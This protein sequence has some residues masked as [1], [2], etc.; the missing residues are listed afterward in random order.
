MQARICSDELARDVS[1]A[2]ALI[3]R[4]KENR[5]EID[6]RLKDFTRFTQKGKA[7]IA[8]KNFL[9]A[10][11]CRILVFYCTVC[12]CAGH[13]LSVACMHLVCRACILCMQSCIVQC[14]LLLWRA[15]VLC[16]CREW[17]TVF[18]HFVSFL[19]FHTFFMWFFTLLSSIKQ[20]CNSNLVSDPLLLLQTDSLIFHF[21]LLFSFKSLWTYFVYT[22]F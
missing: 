16:V 20:G 5:S 19:V 22:L 11:V 4:H 13:A 6:A 7:L 2:E 9:S 8:E 21:W 1:G 14:I 18:M 15:C 17:C 10:E 12:A 3:N